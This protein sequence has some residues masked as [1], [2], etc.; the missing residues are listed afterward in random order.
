MI[1]SINQN[2]KISELF[3]DTKLESNHLKNKKI[4]IKINLAR[5]PKENHPR[6]DAILFKKVIE[7][8]VE[9]NSSI[10]IAEGADGFLKKNLAV[11]GLL[12]F[13]L[14]NNIKIIEIDEAF[15]VEVK[16]NNQEIYIPKIFMDFDYKL[17]LPCT[18][19]RENMLFSNNIKNFVGA[20]PR[21]HYLISNSEKRWRGKLH[22]SLTESVCNIFTAFESKVKFDYYING[23][24]SYSESKGAF[25]FNQ[26]YLSDSAVELDEYIY[27][28]YFSDIEKPEYLK[29]LSF[30]H[31][32]ITQNSEKTE[33]E[34]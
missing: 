24:N 32:F 5:P 9:N 31:D 16:I 10:S 14:G 2:Q 26:Y 21:E 4:L 27:Q 23:G 15:S 1:Q 6:T 19:K 11:I 8:F 22:N 7:Y 18:S 13:V 12:D 33:G 17:S 29:K 34:M 3:V 28:K 20:I 25:N 30:I